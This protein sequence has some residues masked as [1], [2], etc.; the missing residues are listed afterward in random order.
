MPDAQMDIEEALAVLGLQKGASA[1]DIRSA[2]RHL[3]QQV[4]PDQGGNDYLAAKINQARDI[5]LK[6]ND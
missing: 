1:E 6:N 4:H 2:H 3:M 5:L